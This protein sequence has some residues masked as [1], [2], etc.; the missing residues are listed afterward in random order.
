ME[1][2]DFLRG[3]GAALVGGV[4]L[5]LEA[6]STSSPPASGPEGDDNQAAQQGTAF[7]SV[8]W[9]MATSWPKT[10]DILHAAATL[11]AERVAEMTD[12][13]FKIDVF[14][15]GELVG[16]LDVF[17]AVKDGTIECSHTGANFHTNQNEAFGITTGLPF[18]L[19]PQQQNAWI[20]SGGGLEATQKLYADFGMINFPAGNTGTQMGG[21]FKQEINGL[22]DLKGLKMRI[23]GLGGTVMQNLGVEPVTLA[24]SDVLDA[25]KTGEL[26]AA[27]WLGPYDDEKLGFHTVAP[28]YY[29]P[30]WWEPGT[31]LTIIINK[32]AWDKLPRAYQHILEAAA[33]EAN[34]AMLSQYEALNQ[35]ALAQ[36]VAS[37]TQLK[38]YSEEILLAALEA[39]FALY[40]ELAE[41]N[42]SF[43]AIYNPWKDFRRH[44]Y[45][46]SRFNELRF[47]E[48]AFAHIM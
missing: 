38:A 19:T 45:Q 30:G 44:I 27:E 41:T 36:L 26:D 12:G 3:V 2:R 24:S 28:Y 5:G 11:I 14:A 16:A 32:Q 1:R 8:T 48:F 22:D 25:L 31:T 46:W 20:Y 47:A 34:I 39:A 10:L 17:D 7:P 40:E 42:Q 23:P 4:G 21:W 35:Q 6:C 18:G 37:G 33:Y 13:Q 29:Y 9:R 15:A 43:K